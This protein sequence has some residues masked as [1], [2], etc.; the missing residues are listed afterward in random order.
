MPAIAALDA[1]HPKQTL[2]QRN[3]GLSRL[4][5]LPVEVRL[6]IYELAVQVDELIQPQQIAEGSNKFVWDQSLQL[7][8]RHRVVHFYLR[9][10]IKR[11]VVTQ[12]ARTCRM[13]YHELEAKPVFYRLN[14][15]NFFH[16]ATLYRFLAA[17]T[18]ERRRSIRRITIEREEFQP[19]AL[20]P[21]VVIAWDNIMPLLQ[22]C[23]DLQQLQLTLM[24]EVYH[25]E[26]Q[27]YTPVDA[28]RQELNNFRQW[29]EVSPFLSIPGS[30]VVFRCSLVRSDPVVKKDVVIGPNW[31][32][33]ALQGILAEPVQQGLGT[34]ITEIG[35]FMASK[36][37]P[38]SM[39]GEPVKVT[40]EQLKTSIGNALIHFPGE[41]RVHQNRL[42]SDIGA[43]SSRTRHRCNTAKVNASH[44]TVE[45][46]VGR[47]N[48]EGLLMGDF[49]IEDVRLVGSV[50]ECEIRNRHSI[51]SPL[52]A[53]DGRVMQS[54]PAPRDVTFVTD[55]YKQDTGNSY[56]VRQLAAYRRTWEM[57]QSKYEALMEKL[58]IKEEGKRTMPRE[59]KRKEKMKKTK[60]PKFATS[61]RGK[62]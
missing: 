34:Q 56:E 10:P 17:I 37:T 5:K 35:R 27:T 54:L 1:P 26:S 24:K 21:E 39:Q 20:R 42:G 58:A 57:L 23:H 59:T 43:I 31:D 7:P 41:D 4:L 18:P 47:Y 19:C 60:A 2:T 51:R 61:D 25:F 48:L 50:I 62:K 45:R 6:L 29:L 28:V 40:D 3:A 14:S 32:G 53:K 11:L 36:M 13:I 38:L 15:F 49:T 30:Q 44:G 9:D 22:Q 46:T 16:V 12:L 33:T 52:A 55:I 8:C